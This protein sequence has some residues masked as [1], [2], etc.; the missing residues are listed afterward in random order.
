MLGLEVDGVAHGL[1]DELLWAEILSV[2][3]DLVS[4]VLDLNLGNA[5]GAVTQRG[6]REQRLI[7]VEQRGVLHMRL[8]YVTY[9]L[10]N[11]SLHH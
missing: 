8:K 2:D 3:H 5:V 10:C 6:G 1:Y 4:V 11:A 7:A 9:F